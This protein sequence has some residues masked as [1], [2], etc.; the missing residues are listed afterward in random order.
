LGGLLYVP[1][2]DQ[3]L[4]ARGGAAAAGAIA[5]AAGFFRAAWHDALPLVALLPTG[6]G[7]WW[8]RV[9]KDPANDRFTLPALA[10]CTL[11]V[12]FVLAALLRVS[13]FTRNFCPLLPPLAITC[14]WL[15]GEVFIAARRFGRPLEAANV[16]AFAGLVVVTAAL[17]PW[18][19]TYPAR[20]TEFRR[21]RFAQDGY[22]E[23]YAANFHPSDV[24]AHLKQTIPPNE[25]YALCYHESDAWNLVYYLNDYRLDQQ[26]ATDS[27]NQPAA[28][29]RTVYYIQPA[30]PPKPD[31]PLICETPLEELQAAALVRDFGYFRLRQVPASLRDAAWNRLPAC[32]F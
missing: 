19:L 29:A 32:R 24:I 9:R 26:R 31:D 4:A 16:R 20:L 3:V 1:I 11:L 18:V 14:G 30:S 21:E 15:L 17:L 27:S 28:R 8:L 22:Y 13:P 7:L 2:Y 6:F 10:I 23:Y 5:V 12:P 25:P